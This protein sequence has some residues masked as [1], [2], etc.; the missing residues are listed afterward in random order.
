MKDEERR[1]PHASE[2]WT[3]DGIEDGPRGRVARIE[4]EDGQTFDLPLSALPDGVREGDLLAV[5]DGPD[6]VTVRL[7]PGET[8]AR[9]MAAQRHLDRLNAG[10]S[11][12]GEEEITL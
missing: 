4:R 1:D 12:E 6:G 2:R 3:V 9:R 8:R 5:E 10:T 7:L 11:H